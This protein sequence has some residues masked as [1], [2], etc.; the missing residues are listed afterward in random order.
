MVFLSRSFLTMPIT[1]QEA[2]GF[3]RLH[4]RS[5]QC[6]GSLSN[7]YLTPSIEMSHRGKIALVNQPQNPFHLPITNTLGKHG[8]TVKK[9]PTF[10]RTPHRRNPRAMILTQGG[11][12]KTK[13]NIH[14]NKP[15]ILKQENTIFAYELAS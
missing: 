12:V 14:S 4:N 1:S 13:I 3:F 5:I 10:L 11:E 6:D 8:S 7:P 2:E 15:S 9:I